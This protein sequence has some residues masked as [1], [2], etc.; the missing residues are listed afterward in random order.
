MTSVFGAVLVFASCA[1]M[2]AY[3]ASLYRRAVEE[4]EAFYD[5]A[6]YIGAQI[7]SF[8]VPLDV[9]YGSYTDKRLE[10][11][12]FLQ[13]LRENGGTEALM[14]VREK[15]YIS[16]EA[17]GELERFFSGL[18]RHGPNDEVR[19]CTACTGRLAEILKAEKEALGGKVKLCRAFGALF[20]IML[21]VILL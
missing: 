7:D 20:G 1:A 8:L 18:G 12:G 2:G 13:A 17:A 5:L 15:L 4:L 10:R 6:V 3:A 21:A 11:V 9:I 14:A 16:N 19:Y